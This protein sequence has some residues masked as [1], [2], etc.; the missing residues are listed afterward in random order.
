MKRIF[1]GIALAVSCMSASKAEE[2]MWLLPLLEKFNIGDMRKMGC[3]LT[4]E[5]IYDINH[6]SLKDAVA[7]LGN[8]CT[9]EMISG[10]G[11]VLTN[12]H[13]GYGSI[14]EHS[15]PEHNYLE[16]GFWAK[17]RMEE[18]STPGLTVTFLIRIDDVTERIDSVW[19]PDMTE[20][21]RETLIKQKIGDIEEEATRDNWY[22]ASVKSFFGGNRYYLLVY[23]VFPDVR[24]V[25]APP[26]SIG[27]F[28]A[29]TDNWMWPRHTGDFSMFR[30]YADSTG[31]PAACS[32]DNI[33]LKP[34]HHL[35]ISLKGVEKND[36]T[37]ILGFPGST[38]RY[39]TSCEVKQLLENEL[40]NRVK[41][42][43]EKQEIM[44]RHMS[45]DETVRLKY[46]AKYSQSSNYW[47]NAIGMMQGIRRLKV[48]DRKVE[49]EQHFVQWLEDHPEQKT[50]CGEALSMIEAGVEQTK[51]YE[52]VMQYAIECFFQGAELM[53]FSLQFNPLLTEMKKKKPD[54]DKIAL[55]T[56][57]LRIQAD[58]FYKNY[59]AALDREV[60]E[61]MLK[62]Y[63]DDIAP[64]FHPAFYRTVAEKY[65]GDIHRYMQDYSKSFLT[66][67]EQV[68][69]FLQKPSVKVLEKDP[70][71]NAGKS[72]RDACLPWM[73]E[74]VAAE[75]KKAKGQ[76]LYITG[77][78]AMQPEKKWYPDANFTMRL[79]YGSIQDYFPRDA[80]YYNY[81]TTLQG[82]MEKEIPDNW[83]F[84]VPDRLKELYARKDYAPYANRQGELP[85]CFIS[86]NDI[87]G[88]NSGSPVINGKGQLVGLAFDGNWE[89]MSG[90]IAFE[91]DLQRTISVDIR[92]VLFII[93]KFAGA[94]HLIDEMTIIR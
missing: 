55:I 47:K 33:P 18:I 88:G 56:E 52:K 75:N 11:L 32:P 16:D 76:R 8:F 71:L 53:L 27:K 19:N 83:E 72:L 7:M 17:T 13:C 3:E 14:Q 57:L 89:A 36:F 69:A 73:E 91:P 40:P 12:H 43:G 34:R 50:V 15:T 80:V 63:R 21:L 22:K 9:C 92:Y 93:D 81:Y 49:Q 28:G 90:D 51:D 94:K 37:M 87:T 24:M 5:Q 58:A 44:R 6:S 54:Y 20:E 82:V 78:Q 48:Y 42:R 31:K 38:E 26:S 68:K 4:A 41:I 60:T 30:V 70:V 74:I 39:A 62:I 10:E 1:I 29:D 25:G 86:T 77:L 65:K 64:A 66:D 46:A 67:A 2:G 61:A 45:A 23:E 85:L 84:T 35:P 79:T 59:D